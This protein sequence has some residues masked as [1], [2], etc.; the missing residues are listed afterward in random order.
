MT[1]NFS[2]KSAIHINA[3]R[4]RVW[5]ALTTPAEIKQWFFGVDTVTD[6]RVGS[7]IVHTGVWQGKPYEDKGDIIRFTPPEVL[8]HSHW[9]SLSSLPDKPENYQ[10]VTW[11]LAEQGGGTDLTVSEVNIPGE[12]AQALSEK[13]WQMV[14]GNLKSLLEQPPSRH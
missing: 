8:E 10:H 4:A 12:T 1:T 11:A 5:A 3:P 6:W 9:S 13:S 14:L 7:P 2:A